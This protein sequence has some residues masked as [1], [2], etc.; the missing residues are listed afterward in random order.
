MVLLD[1]PTNNPTNTTDNNI[2]DNV[3]NVDN[4]DMS[5]G[6]LAPGLASFLIEKYLYFQITKVSLFLDLVWTCWRQGVS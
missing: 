1:S 5:T 3:D 4:V 6:T 2:V